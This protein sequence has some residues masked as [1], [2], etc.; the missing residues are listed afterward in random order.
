MSTEYDYVIIGAGTAGCVLAARLSEDPAFHIALVEAGHEICDPAVA[1]PLAWPSLQ[2][3]AVDWQHA[4]VPQHHA[5]GRAHAWP[6]GKGIGGSSCINAMAHVRGHPD[7]FAAWERAGCAG[8]GYRDLMPYFI[9][10]EHSPHGPSPWHGIHGPVH[11][12]QPA[13]PHPVTQAYMAAGIERGVAPTDEHNGPQ[14]AGATVNTLTIEGNRRQTVADA[15]LTEAVR[16]RSNLSILSGRTA[17]RLILDAGRCRGVAVRGETGREEIRAGRGVILAAGA[18]GSPVLLLRS[19]V[20]SADILTTAGIAVRHDLP[21][22]GRNLHDHLLSGGNVYRSTR[23]VPPSRYQHSE[24]LMYIAGEGAGAAPEL[25]LACVIAPATTEAFVPIPAG[26]AYTILYGFT[27]PQSR[28]SITVTSPDPAVQPRIDPAYLAHEEDRRRYLE[29]LDWAR[30][31]G[32]AAAL[33]D[34]RAEELLPKPD[35]LASP[36]ARLNFVQRAAYTHHHPCGTCRMGVDEEAVVG[37]DL[38]VRGLEG[39]YVVD[40]SVMPSITSGPINAAVIAI[41]ERASDVIAGRP[42][43][44]P[45][46][47]RAGVGAAV[48]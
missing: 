12:I 20:G 6:R 21:G 8:W 10:S 1:D 9:R 41:A 35:D 18:I 27:H 31:V 17:E 46:D 34:W 2:G 11:L 4:T 45:H 38:A 13:D 32:S 37:P 14:M 47:P 42:V 24:S 25:V 36:A 40:A 7:D 22:V 16:A 33:A 29:A 3:S 15:Y 30:A 5:G 48:R 23:P 19:G 39:L 44:P 43:L 28:G 26:T